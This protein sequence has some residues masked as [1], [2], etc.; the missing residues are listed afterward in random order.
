MKKGK[1]GDVDGMTTELMKAD[2]E[3]TVAVL[4]GLLLKIW[5]SERV[6]N[7]W[8]CRLIIRLPKR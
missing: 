1:A 6:P 7:K 2:L 5:E 3:T 4:Y 8:R